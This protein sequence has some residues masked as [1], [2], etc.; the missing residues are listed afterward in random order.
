MRPIKNRVCFLTKF[1]IVSVL[2]KIAPYHMQ[3]FGSS[4]KSLYLCTSNR[5]NSLLCRNPVLIDDRRLPSF[6][7]RCGLLWW[8]PSGTKGCSFD[9]RCKDTKKGWGSNGF[10][11][12][13][14]SF[15]P[16]VVKPGGWDK[17]EVSGMTKQRYP[18][19]NDRSLSVIKK[20]QSG[21]LAL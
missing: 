3:K 21:H 10:S 19:I 12:H 6:K 17:R 18:G 15:F 7:T 8:P 20:N 9:C 2:L 14:N 1:Q 13:L 5:R 4:R 16:Y 11:R